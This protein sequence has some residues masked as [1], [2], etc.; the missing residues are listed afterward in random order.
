VGESG[1]KWS[2]GASRRSDIKAEVEQMFLGQYQHSLDNKG[3]LTIPVRYRE[4][5][6]D[7]AYI[8]QGFERNL[9]V[10]TSASFQAISQRVNQMSVTDP[11]ARS[12]RRLI[13]SHGEQVEVDKAGRILIPQFLR[14]FAGLASDVNIVGAGDYFEI[15][16]PE[17]WNE[18]ST[19]LQD[20]DANAQRFVAFDIS[21]G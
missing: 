6:A 10:L 19:Q 20:T 13:F 7:G 21:S 3:R 17:G 16:S 12:L 15:W 8:T 5:L 9:M 2:A 11:E 18:Q 4:I 1:R 14:D